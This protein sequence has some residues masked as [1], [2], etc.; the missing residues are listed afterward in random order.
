MLQRPLKPIVIRLQFGERIDMTQYFEQNGI[1]VKLSIA[2]QLNTVT[3]GQYRS[4]IKVW[5][6]P[7]LKL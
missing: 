6:L 1:E 7:I 3:S 4:L 5:L 2:Y